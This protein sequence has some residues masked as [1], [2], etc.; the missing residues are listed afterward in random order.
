ML[1]LLN[2]MILASGINEILKY[3]GSKS[4]LNKFCMTKANC[5]SNLFPKLLYFLNIFKHLAFVYLADLKKAIVKIFHL[6][7]PK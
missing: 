3:F 5:N 2:T 1:E 4:S 7:R 6:G